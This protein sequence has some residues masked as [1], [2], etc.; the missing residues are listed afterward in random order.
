[1][2]ANI[3]SAVAGKPNDS[4]TSSR[5]GS[6]FVKPD[7][8]VCVADTIGNSNSTARPRNSSAIDL[9]Y[10]YEFTLPPGHILD[11]AQMFM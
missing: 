1:M 11:D 4:E 8:V 7:L 9:I 2:I 6:E 3:K 5:P 10:V